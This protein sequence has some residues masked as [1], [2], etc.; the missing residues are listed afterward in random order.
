M[1]KKKKKQSANTLLS[2]RNA[3]LLGII[4]FQRKIKQ[5]QKWWLQIWVRCHHGDFRFDWACDYCC[6]FKFGFGL[7][8]L[9]NKQTRG[10]PC[11]PLYVMHF[12]TNKSQHINT[13]QDV[14]KMTLST[15]HN[16]DDETKE[17]TIRTA[18]GTISWKQKRKMLSEGAKEEGR[19]QEMEKKM[20]ERKEEEEREKKGGVAI[21][22]C[23]PL[24]PFSSADVFGVDCFNKKTK[25]ITEAS[26]YGHSCLLFFTIFRYLA[27]GS[28][29][30]HLAEQTKDDSH[31]D[32]KRNREHFEINKVQHV[33]EQQH[34]NCQ[35]KMAGNMAT[36][37]QEEGRKHLRTSTLVL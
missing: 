36:C 34:R 28:L 2:E 8:L 23:F 25:W 18:Y 7:S 29:L 19:K 14:Q 37:S 3:F 11:L 32:M 4:T 15:Q 24:S 30:L 9:K 33:Q 21:M 20:G 31:I 16:E 6:R 27:H 26:T 5:Q 17:T 1:K 13:W 10:Q 12:Y 35:K 22:S